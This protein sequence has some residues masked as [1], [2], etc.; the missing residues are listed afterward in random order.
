MAYENRTRDS[1]R[2]K[3]Y[4]WEDRIS[5][6]FRHH[7]FDRDLSLEECEELVAQVLDYYD[8]D[9]QPRVVDGRGTTRARGSA[10][11]ISLPV[12]SRTELIVIHETCHCIKSRIGARGASHGPEFV[13]IELNVLSK[14]FGIKQAALRHT[15]RVCKV[16]VAPADPSLAPRKRVRG[17]GLKLAR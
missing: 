13:R 5:K 12:W 4:R 9:E 16:K 14:H 11:R 7:G 8:E 6:V 17:K 10:Y 15:A 2:S 3:V 1:Q